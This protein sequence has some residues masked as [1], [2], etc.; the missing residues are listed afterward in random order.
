[1][2]R[3]FSCLTWTTCIFLLPC[4][5]N[6][7]AEETVL[8]HGNAPLPVAYKHFPNRL[9]AFVWRNWNAVEPAKLAAIV[10]TSVDNI[11]A[12]AVSM[13]LPAEPAVSPALKKR[14][15]ATLIRRNWHLLP[16]GQLLELVEMSPERLAFT[17][18]EEDFLWIKLGRLK[19]RCEPLRYE[20]PD[21]T[22]QQRAHEIRSWVE[23]VFGSAI[24]T[25]GVPR[26]DFVRKLQNPPPSYTP[27]KTGAETKEPL[28]LVYSY[29]ALY[30]D[31]LLTPEL[32]PYPDG[33]LARLS[34][35]GINGVWLQGLLR[36]LAPGGDTFP[37]FGVHHEKRLANL[38]ALA[39]RAKKF[40]IGVYLYI[41]E[42]RAM[43]ASFF[44]DHPDVAGVQ[45]GDLT[46]LCTSHPAVRQWMSDALAYIFRETP[47]LAGV[48]AITASENLTNCASHGDWTSCERCKTRGD[49]DILAEVAGVI[50]EGVHRGNPNAA[51]LISDWGWRGHGNAPDIIARLPKSICLMSVSEWALPIE[52]GGIKSTVGEYSISSVGPGPRALRHWNAAREAGLKT[53]AEI[54]F[55]NTCE[56]ATVPY[57]PV[58]NLVAEHCQNLNAAVE[59]DAMLI[60]WT[61][62]GYPSPNFELAHRLSRTP[63]PSIDSLLDDLARERFGNEGAPHA[64]KAWTLMSDAFR[65]YPFHISV[66][67]TSPVQCGPANPLYPSK[68]GYSATMWGI[69]YDDLE[70]WRG[71]Y[72]PDIFAAQFE[73]MAERWRQGIGELKKAAG[74]SPGDRRGL[75]E[76]DLRLAQ[77]AG[78]HFQSVA[79]QARYVMARNAIADP[80]E[81]V[82]AQQRDRYQSEMER[83]LK[84][85]IE[86]A[87][88]LFTLTR[89]DSRIGFEPSCQYF[90]L[91][92]DL[93]EKVINCRWLLQQLGE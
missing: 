64:R 81:T 91:P 70:G 85:E 31:P 27:P 82:S 35:V 58:M 53:G 44:K 51:V 12:L 79:N 32:N 11:T 71:P 54:Q 14:G 21:K 87:R 25:P 3:I 13:G 77:A 23:K 59:L 48:Y 5:D 30:G 17:L 49:A 80:S 18:R 86:L 65:E 76:T 4:P 34:E 28:K 26:F 60:G 41:N 7:L 83:C 42:P 1:M 29:V 61:M 46:A 74:K 90:Y 62:G 55:N 69:P 68:T 9:H 67:Y 22:V 8:P 84:S 36:D 16:Y 6:A 57:L 20:A 75:A 10:G 15:Y 72:P 73:K 38:R 37:E 2:S 33:L 93:V 39:A 19:P 56:I 43:P 78:I 89:E 45:E 66:V 92:L 40:G 24:Q 88:Q 47:E 50:E 63:A 52:R